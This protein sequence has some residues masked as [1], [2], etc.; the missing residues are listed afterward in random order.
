[1]AVL[2]WVI[3]CFLWSPKPSCFIL[4]APIIGCR[5]EDAAQPQVA[6]YTEAP[7]RRPSPTHPSSSAAVH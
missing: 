4:F 1:M 6:L 7:T 3:R 2:G 5:L